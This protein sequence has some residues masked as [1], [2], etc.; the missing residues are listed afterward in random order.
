MSTSGT[1]AGSTY[2]R[3]PGSVAAAALSNARLADADFV[4]SGGRSAATGSPA[5]YSGARNGGGGS[6]SGLIS[7]PAS[8]IGGDEE[9]D[10][11]D[12][13]DGDGGEHEDD[14]EGEE[15]GG[16]SGGKRGKRG[17]LSS[18]KRQRVHFS[19][20]YSSSTYTIAWDD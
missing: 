1:G 12:N 4:G 14:D 6:S 3:F 10:D 17:S 5:E 8:V 7:N 15:R 16:G 2:G 9:D 19:C 11:E 18:S 20:V 13:G